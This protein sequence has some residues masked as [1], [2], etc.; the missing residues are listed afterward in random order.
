[1]LN[2]SCPPDPQEIDKEMRCETRYLGLLTLSSQ[3]NAFCNVVFAFVYCNAT[4]QAQIIFLIP[5]IP[6]DEAE[7]SHEKSLDKSLS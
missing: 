2:P 3:V 5:K 4:L 7:T 1:M 6:F